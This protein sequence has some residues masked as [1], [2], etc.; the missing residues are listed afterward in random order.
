MDLNYT[1]V[2]VLLSTGLKLEARG[3]AAKR[4]WEAERR[5][6]E[7]KGSFA[8]I[9]ENLHNS[10]MQNLASFGEILPPKPDLGK[11]EVSRRDVETSRLLEEDFCIQA[12]V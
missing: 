6:S 8:E 11:A 9:G 4:R 1:S 7:E 2:K 3:R 12:S 5:I 10:S